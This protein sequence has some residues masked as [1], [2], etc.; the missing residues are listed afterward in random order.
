MSGPGGVVTVT[1]HAGYQP[2][3]DCERC[4]EAWPC[5]AFRTVPGP[6]VDP[7]ALTRV[8]PSLLRDAIRDLRGRPE[9]PEPP[10]I[11]QRFLWFLPLTDDEARAVACRMR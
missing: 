5:P 7:A 4:G 10:Q 8:M 2:T 9:G 1:R 11:V 6:H 3:W